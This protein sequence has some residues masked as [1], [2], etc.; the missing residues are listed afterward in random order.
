MFRKAPH[1]YPRLDLFGHLVAD[2]ERD[3]FNELSHVYN[4]FTLFL[5]LSMG[6]CELPLPII[7]I[8]R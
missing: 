4:V 5:Q 2:V 8:V 3:S 1:F 7:A 6:M